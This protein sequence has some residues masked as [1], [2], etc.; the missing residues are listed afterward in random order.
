M[1]L[2]PLSGGKGFAQVD[3]EDYE[4]LKQFKWTLTANGYAMAGVR[5]HRLVMK[6]PDGVEVDHIKGDRLDN[7]K[8]SL[9]LCTP[10]QNSQN[11][12]QYR[13]TKSGFKG[14]IAQSTQPHRFQAKICYKRKAYHLGTFKKRETAAL[15]YD[16][17]ATEIFGEFA[18][19]NFKVV[20]Q[21]TAQ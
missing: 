2:I 13:E 3:D 10:A 12:K 14:V 8:R 6:A 15:M 19:T 11:K 20:S 1:K 7:Q 4:F 21:W 18:Q 5:M 17:W 16:F 9:R